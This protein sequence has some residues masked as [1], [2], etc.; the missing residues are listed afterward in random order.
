[1]AHKTRHFGVRMS[2][3]GI[4]GEMVDL[5]REFGEIR[6]DK[7][8]LDR[9]DLER[10]VRRVREIER[11]ALKLLDKG[12]VAVIETDG[13]LVTTYNVD[14]RGQRRD[15]GRPKRARRPRAYECGR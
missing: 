3:R 5:V 14:G 7:T 4:T 8:E 13:A 2:Q 6:Q 15:R 1:M 11:V 9:R 12:G 10:L